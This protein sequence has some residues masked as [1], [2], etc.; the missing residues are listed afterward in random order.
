MNEEIELLHKK[1]PQELIHLPLGVKTVGCRW[2]YIVKYK[3]NG[4]IECFIARLV[5]TGYTQ[6]YSLDY[7]ETFALV[8]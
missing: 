7:M 8:P 3:K 2:I 4:F 5:A 1:K 6:I